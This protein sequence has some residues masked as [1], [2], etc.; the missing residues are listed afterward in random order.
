MSRFFGFVPFGR[1]DGYKTFYGS[2]NR[3]VVGIGE[4]KVRCLWDYFILVTGE[5]Y[6]TRN[7]LSTPSCVG[8]A[9]A[10][11]IDFLRMV[12]IGG[13]GLPE[14]FTA[15]ADAITIYGGSRYEIGYKKYGM[16]S[17]IRGGGSNTRFAVEYLEDYG[18]LEMRQYGEYD[19]SEFTESRCNSWGSRGVPDAIEK[20][21]NILIGQEYVDSYEEARDAIYY[22][23]PVAVGSNRGFETR[24]GSVRDSEGFLAPGG[25]WNH[26]MLFIGVDDNPERPG[27]ICQNSWGERWVSG[28]TYRNMPAGSFKVDANV[29]DKMLRQGSS[30]ALVDVGTRDA[31]LS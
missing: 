25:T 23:A 29:A 4:G 20:S 12:R 22:G 9:V 1:P 16:K 30:A 18:Y 14:V 21:Q 5:N 27:L 28:P 6:K 15:P 10:A 3:K 19:L 7:Q 17:M 8:Q 31:R 11:G 24:R 26:E 13:L 2:H